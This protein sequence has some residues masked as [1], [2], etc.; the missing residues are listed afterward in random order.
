MPQLTDPSAIRTLLETGRRWSVYALGDL[1]PEQFPHCA[2]FREAGDAPALV[3][4]YRGFTPPVL[5]T[6]GPPAAV[7]ALLA[8]MGGLPALFLHVRPEVVPFLEDHYRSR[9]P[10]RCGAWS[11]NRHSSGRPEPKA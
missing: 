2:W 11:S 6:L 1:S 8:E 3:L 7:P 5:F 4:L 9:T 10:A